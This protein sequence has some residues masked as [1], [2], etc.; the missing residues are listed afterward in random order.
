MNDS[1]IRYRGNFSFKC[2]RT[3]EPRAG[4][5]QDALTA[6]LHSVNAIS[7]HPVYGTFSTA[8]SDGTI[9]FWDKT[10]KT[11]L[12]STCNRLLRGFKPHCRSHQT[13]TFVTALDLGQNKTGA[14]SDPFPVTAT[15]FNH[16][17]GS[18]IFAYAT[19]YDWA[20]GYRGLSATD[21]QRIILH[22]C[23]VSEH[24]SDCLRCSNHGDPRL[25]RSRTGGRNQR[26]A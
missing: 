19:S 5:S 2:H 15:A 11:R 10:N 21:S 3:N 4:H 23:K 7:F 17:N 14:V 25:H 22:S 1:C 8:G 18:T 9:S 16:R 6:R 26:K 24:L 13:L 20:R 12:K